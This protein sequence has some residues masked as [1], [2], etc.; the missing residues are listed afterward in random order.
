[1]CI[2]ASGE[3]DL[4]VHFDR[5]SSTKLSSAQVGVVRGIDEVVRQRL[6]HV[7]VVVEAVEEHGS[8]VVGHQIA[9]QAVDRQTLWTPKTTTHSNGDK[10]LDGR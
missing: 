4:P 9:A 6:I 1:M 10:T 7:L 2:P 3:K 5:G 8:V